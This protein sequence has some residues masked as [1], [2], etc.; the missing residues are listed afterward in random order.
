MGVRLRIQRRRKFNK[1]TAQVYQGRTKNDDIEDIGIKK[2][3]SFEGIH[4]FNQLFAFVRQDREDF[5]DFTRDW[6]V[7]KRETMISNSRKRNTKISQKDLHIGPYLQ[8][9]VLVQEI[10]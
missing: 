5:P 6:L 4:C 7:Q 9:K 2:G 8:M 10:L 1:Y 3:W